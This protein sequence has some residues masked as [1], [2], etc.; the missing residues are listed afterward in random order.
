MG[1]GFRDKGLEFRIPRVSIQPRSDIMHP[2]VQFEFV[3]PGLLAQSRM[4]IAY[5]VRNT[6]LLNSEAL[7]GHEARIPDAFKKL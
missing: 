4:I 1:L 5:A 6:G 3:H 2:P 7:N